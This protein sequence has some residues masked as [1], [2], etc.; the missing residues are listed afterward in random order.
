VQVAQVRHRSL[1]FGGRAF[2]ARAN[3]LTVLNLLQTLT[4]NVGSILEN[5]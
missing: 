5:E 2:S 1:P 4:K 3:G